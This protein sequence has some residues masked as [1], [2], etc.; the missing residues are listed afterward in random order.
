MEDTNKDV[1]LLQNFLKEI[2]WTKEFAK[3]VMDG[4]A[5]VLAPEDFPTLEQVIPLLPSEGE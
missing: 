1:A 3:L 2:G 4:K 5:R